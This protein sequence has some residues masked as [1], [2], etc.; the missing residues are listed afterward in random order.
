[1]SVGGLGVKGLESLRCVCV[2]AVEGEECIKGAGPYQ[3][4]LM[5]KRER[6]R[7]RQRVNVEMEDESRHV[8]TGSRCMDNRKS[9]DPSITGQSERGGWR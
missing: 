7:E 6:E 9:C 5:R 8:R 1:M 4:L 3:I 2:F